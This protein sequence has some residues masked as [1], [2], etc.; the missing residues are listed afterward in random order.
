[1]TNLDT[2]LSLDYPIQPLLTEHYQP[3]LKIYN[4]VIIHKKK[5]DHIQEII[6]RWLVIDDEIWA[7]IICME[8][9]RRIAKA[10]ARRHSLTINGSEDEYLDGTTL[11][12][13]CFD[14]PER[15]SKTRYIKQYIGQVRI[16]K[17]KKTRIQF[18]NLLSCTYQFSYLNRFLKE[19]WFK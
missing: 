11:G 6:D 10:Y 8:R 9:N 15:S 14:N 5:Q 13:N 18:A 16:K 4:N 1:M 19:T 12:L 3:N 2:N 17:K 7:K